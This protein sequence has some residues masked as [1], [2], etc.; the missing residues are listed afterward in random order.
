MKKFG[1]VAYELELPANAKIHPVFHISQLKKKMGTGIIVQQ[2]VP[3][4]I[5]TII[6]EP[7]TIIGRRIVPR[8]NK[9]VT[10]VLVR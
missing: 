1:E 8:N 7:E 3:T 10:K 9:A 2:D 5:E 6:D 4:F